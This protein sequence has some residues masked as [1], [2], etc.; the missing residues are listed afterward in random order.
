VRAQRFGMC[1]QIGLIELDRSREASP[2]VSE[3]GPAFVETSQ[4]QS[5]TGGARRGRAFVEQLR[6][7][8]RHERE[9]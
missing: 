6:R 8:R 7:A 2:R 5:L 3:H 4:S 1:Q 9:R